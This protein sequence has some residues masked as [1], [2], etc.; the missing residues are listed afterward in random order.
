MKCTLLL[1]QR[2]NLACSYCYVGK[3]P[4]TMSRTTAR[5]VIEFAFRHAP[6]EERIDLGFFGGEPLLEFELI[7]SV[8][9]MIEDAPGFDPGRVT[10]TLVTNGTLFSV[11]IAEFLDA[12][13]IGFGVSCDGPPEIHD[14][15]RRYPDGSGSGSDVVRTILSAQEAG[16]PLL[17]NAVYGPRTLEALP[18]TVRFLS[19]LGVR[20]IYLNPDFSAPWSPRDASRLPDV[21]DRVG[22]LYVRLY[23]EGRPHFVSLLDGKIAVILRG[24]YEPAERCRMGRAE[25]AFTPDGG[26][27]P[28]ERLVGDGGE[29]HRIGHVASGL[30]TGRMLCHLASGSEKDPECLT[31][32]L[33]EYCMHWCACSNYLA[34]GH[35]NRVGGFLCAS[36][37]AAIRTARSVCERLERSLGSTFVEHLGGYPLVNSLTR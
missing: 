11:E 15:S 22:R 3:Q 5:Q 23:R 25:F 18:E 20:Q 17:V 34:T 30:Q 16:L 35:Y 26:I 29:R 4:A 33:S 28:C 37:K 9:R 13:R 10:L 2:C 24:G 8:T 27:Y 14:A 36:E 1:T 12:H 21:Y 7:R 32:G 31:C 6:P 19:S